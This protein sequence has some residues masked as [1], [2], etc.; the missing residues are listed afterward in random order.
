MED[1]GK[2]LRWSFSSLNI[3]WLEAFFKGDIPLQMLAD[4]FF[5]LYLAVFR[6]FR[7]FAKLQRRQW[8]RFRAEKVFRAHLQRLGQL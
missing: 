6:H 2:H 5:N 7:P 8:Q 4:L 3:Q 1:T